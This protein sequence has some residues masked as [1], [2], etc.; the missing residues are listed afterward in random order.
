MSK[1]TVGFNPMGDRYAFDF[2][3]CTAAKGWAQ[4]DTSQDASYFGQWINPTTFEY[5]S[6]VE[7]DMTHI[8]YDNRAEF[9][10][11]I[12]ETLKWHADREYNPKIDGM[13]KPEIIEA[14]ADM[15]LAEWL[16]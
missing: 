1:R 10:A 13:C 4:L 15:G 11:G 9:I 16:H 12:I 2:K 6:Y 14:F 3:C 7:G 5:V 8:Q